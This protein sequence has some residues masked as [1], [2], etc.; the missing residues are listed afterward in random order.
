MKVWQAASTSSTLL[1]GPFELCGS[2]S[3]FLFRRRSTTLRTSS[4]SV[5]LTTCFR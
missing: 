4:T 2:L 3:A 5:S 1:L